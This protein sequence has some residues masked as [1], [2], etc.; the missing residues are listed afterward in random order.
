MT[1]RV[2]SV[3]AAVKTPGGEFA[4]CVEVEEGGGDAGRQIRTIYCPGVGPVYL[5]SMMMVRGKEIKV[6]ARLRGHMVGGE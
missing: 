3:N 4:D 2:R 6:T 1:A 5:E